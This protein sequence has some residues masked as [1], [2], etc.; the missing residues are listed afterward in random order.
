[1]YGSLEGDGYG[2]SDSSGCKT[3]E[4]NRSGRFADFSRFANLLTVQ[5][6]INRL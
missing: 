2:Q 1:M 4:Q 6:A 3:N 5:N